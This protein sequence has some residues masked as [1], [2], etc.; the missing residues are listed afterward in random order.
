MRFPAACS[1]S[2]ALARRCSSV[3][4]VNL[5]RRVVRTSA[6]RWASAWPAA[7]NAVW[8]TGLV[9]RC[10]TVSARL[11]GAEPRP[12]WEVGASGAPAPRLAASCLTL[13]VLCWFLVG[14]RVGASLGGRMPSGRTGSGAASDGEGETLTA[15]LAGGFSSSVSPPNLGASA[16]ACLGERGE[17]VELAGLWRALRRGTLGLRA[18]EPP[19]WRACGDAALLFARSESAR[20]G[21]RG[22][23]ARGAGLADLWPSLLP[24]WSGGWGRFRSASVCGLS[25]RA[26][27]SL[28]RGEAFVPAAE[29]VR[30]SGC[31]AGRVTAAAAAASRAARMAAA[32]WGGGVA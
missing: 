26:L 29:A 28:W 5:L 9:L 22:G 11:A 30:V 31:R 23:T 18:T 6:W 21:D 16:A 20:L 1:A 10:A 19:A 25:R 14:S 7:F 13:E 15:P 24:A 17:L 8:R 27:A 32:S 2:R 3:G 4:V 12:P